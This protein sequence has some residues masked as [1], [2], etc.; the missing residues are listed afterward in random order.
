M[1]LRDEYGFNDDLTMWEHGNPNNMISLSNGHRSGF[2]TLVE[3]K[4]KATG[5]VLFR[6]KVHLLPLLH[7][8]HN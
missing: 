1:I 6:G 7:I 2:N 5:E 4:D 3:I 8:I